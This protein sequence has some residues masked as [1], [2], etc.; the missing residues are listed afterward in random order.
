MLHVDD[1]T[2]PAGTKIGDRELAEVR[3][4][5]DKFHGDWNYEVSPRSI[6][7]G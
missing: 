6:H 3:L 2:Y 1:G 4:K 7:N 5:R